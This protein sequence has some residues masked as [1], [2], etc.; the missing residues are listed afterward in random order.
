MS[1]SYVQTVAWRV[2]ASLSSAVA[3]VTVFRLLED[4][5]TPARYG[6]VLVATQALQYLPLIDLGF[7]TVLNRQLLAE[8]D[9][10]RRSALLEFGQRLYALISLLLA[11]VALAGMALYALSP[12]GRQA[13]ESIGFF[14]VLGLSGAASVAAAA[15]TQLLVGLGRQDRVFALNAAGTW[16]NLGVLWLALG[17][18]LD[19][20]AFPLAIA[21]TALV[22]AGPAWIT[23]RSLVP[24]LRWVGRMARTEFRALFVALRPAALACLRSQFA[25]LVLFTVDVVLVDLLT[26]N[27]AVSAVYGIA[28]RVF[29]IAR[30]SLQAGSEA[31]WPRIARAQRDGAGASTGDWLLPANAWVYGAAMGGMAVV[32]HPFID[33]FMSA[34]WAP[35]PVL[36]A[37]MAG[38]FLVTGLSS[39]P[40]YQLLGMGEFRWL[41]R[42]CERELV[43]AVGLSVPLGLGFGA[44]GVALAF[45]LAT[46]AG[47]FTP[48][49]WRWARIRGVAPGGWFAA[50]WLR[51]LLAAGIAVGVTWTILA[52]GV[53]GPG[54]PLAAAAG[55]AAALGVGITT[56][57][58]RARRAGLSRPRPA[59]ILARL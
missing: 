53:S 41:A 26:G 13:G 48:I 21:A 4:H 28:A 22:Q 10:S 45:L 23:T 19:L 42:Y 20:W 55:F 56:G 3:G 34:R 18:G 49:F 15:Q 6:V 27:P 38:R 8:A 25:I 44:R 12:S 47:T 7:R 51:G 29:A 11:A 36:A 17:R 57:I 16:T 54:I 39:P 46:G 33:W 43:L 50:T 59:D 24:G 1:G 52:A 14:L 37:L 32:L 35:D 30:N 31:L 9:P 58:V 40:A 5:L 2:A